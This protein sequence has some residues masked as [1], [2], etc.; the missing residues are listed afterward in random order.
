MQV[1]NVEHT[2][3]QIQSSNKIAS[4]K[5]AHEHMKEHLTQRKRKY[6]KDLQ[7]MREKLNAESHISQDVTVQLTLEK[8]KNEVLSAQMA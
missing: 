4:L 1:R 6:K 8:D 3:L 2:R 5:D 7:T